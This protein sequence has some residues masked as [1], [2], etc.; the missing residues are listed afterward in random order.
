MTI[1][2]RRGVLAIVL[3]LAAAVVCAGPCAARADDAVILYLRNTGAEPLHCRLLFGHWVDRD[4]GELMPSHGVEITMQQSAK[5]G[6]LYIPRDDRQR[7]MMIETIVCGRDGD[8]MASFGQVDLAP[9]RVVRPTRVTASCAAPASAGRV[10]CPP[11]VIE[12]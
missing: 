12:R 1:G 8:W 4:L 5:D 7:L 6:A 2:R 3:S 9:L 11:P 10:A